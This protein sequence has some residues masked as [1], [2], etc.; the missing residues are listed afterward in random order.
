MAVLI[1]AYSVAIF[2]FSLS[3]SAMLFGRG[4][5][6]VFFVGRFRLLVIMLTSFVL[7]KQSIFC[8]QVV[9]LAYCMY[10]WRKK[11]FALKCSKKS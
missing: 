9:V 2:V 7:S 11:Y 1:T 8:R 4:K 6:S 3:L 10:R 5:C